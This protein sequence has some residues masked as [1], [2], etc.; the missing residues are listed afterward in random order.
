MRSAGADREGKCGVG[1]R[2]PGP[3]A[4]TFPQVL[5]VHDLALRDPAQVAPEVLLQLLL[6]PELL[7][8]A[9]GLGLLPLLGEL[10]EVQPGRWGGEQERKKGLREGRASQGQRGHSLWLDVPLLRSGRHLWSTCPS[11]QLRGSLALPLRRPPPGAPWNP[12]ASF[13]CPSHS[14]SFSPALAGGH[15]GH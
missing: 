15:P 14:S 2:W 1:G 12:R 11:R 10:P 8:G 9:P 5:G 3:W 7:E 4:R 13:L 6:L